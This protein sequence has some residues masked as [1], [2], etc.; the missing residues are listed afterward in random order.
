VHVVVLPVVKLQYIFLDHKLEQTSK[1]ISTKGTTESL[2]DPEKLGNLQKGVQCKLM[3]CHRKLVKNRGQCRIT[4]KSKTASRE[5]S[6]NN[7]FICFRGRDLLA[8]RR[9]CIT[10]RKSG[11]LVFLDESR[12][13]FGLTKHIGRGIRLDTLH[14][15]EF[16]RVSFN[17]GK[18][19]LATRL[20]SRSYLPF[21]TTHRIGNNIR[22]WVIHSRPNVFRFANFFPS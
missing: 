18:V 13:D 2:H 19:F 3:Y 5:I 7:H 21:F 6:E 4:W 15:D 8:R 11:F 17:I 9:A 16:T 22:S 10:N 20:V 12:C 14:D 1:N